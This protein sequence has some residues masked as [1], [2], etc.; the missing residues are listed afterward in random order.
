MK[1]LI[2]IV[3]SYAVNNIGGGIYCIT[4]TYCSKLY[5]SETGRRLDDRFREH[6]RDV[7]RNDKD[8]SKPVSRHF[9]LP[10]H[11]IQHVAVCGLSLHLGSS[12]SRKTQEQKFTFQIGTLK[13]ASKTIKHPL[14]KLNCIILHLSITWAKLKGALSCSGSS[15][16]SKAER[17]RFVF[18]DESLEYKRQA[19]LHWFSPA[20]TRNA[21]R[22]NL[23]CRFM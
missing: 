16:S 23:S 11:S 14:V 2:L 19:C 20:K 13:E 5:I 21:N 18:Y 22:M 12:E 7:E 6:L 3:P 9:N 10:N 15:K 1:Q 17:F 8:A 4:C